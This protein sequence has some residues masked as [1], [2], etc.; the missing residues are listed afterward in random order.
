MET[1]RLPE[2]AAGMH[3]EEVVWWKTARL[4]MPVGWMD[5][6]ARKHGGCGH[7]ML[8]A[9]GTGSFS[10]GRPIRRMKPLDAAWQVNGCVGAGGG[11]LHPQICGFE[12]CKGTMA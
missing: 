4:V 6:G 10:L 12:A 3:P 8:Q 2:P 11:G 5:G 1:C 9:C 7:S